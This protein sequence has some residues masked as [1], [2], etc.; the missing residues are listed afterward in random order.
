MLINKGDF[1]IPEPLD[2]VWDIAPL[3]LYL[4]SVISFD[5]QFLSP[6]HEN[7]VHHFDLLSDNQ[8]ENYI[9]G[10]LSG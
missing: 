1:K 2:E 6:C 8:Q 7:F 3:V 10:K 9:L 5:L 4:C